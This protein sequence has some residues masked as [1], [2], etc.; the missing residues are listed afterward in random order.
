MQLFKGI[1]ILSLAGFLAVAI[2]ACGGGDDDD[3][4]PTDPI[5][6]EL[7]EKGKAKVLECNLPGATFDP[8][9]I[10]NDARTKCAIQCVVDATCE[11]ILDVENQQGPFYQCQVGC[12]ADAG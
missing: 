8:C 4:G 10:H 11:Q 9:N 1:S 7:C 5:A 2:G 12:A 6:T 3:V